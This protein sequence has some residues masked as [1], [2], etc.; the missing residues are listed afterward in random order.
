MSDESGTVANTV[1]KFVLQKIHWLDRIDMDDS[2]A[3]AA[4]AILRRGLGKEP[5]ALPEIW[6]IT[7]T[8]NSDDSQLPGAERDE[9][10]HGGP[11]RAERAVH[12][13]LTFYALHRQGQ[14]HSMHKGNA[15]KEDGTYFSDSSFG[16][17]MG[18]LRR[19]AA[20][21]PGVIRRFNAVI[22]AA[23]LTEF[24]RHAQGIVR[25]MRAAVV[26]IPMDY[27][28]FVR[29]LFWYQSPEKR[30]N[31]VMRWG[32]QFW[33]DPVEKKQSDDRTSTDTGASTEAR[34]RL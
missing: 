25:M 27:G 8:R 6:A 21:A 3:R 9:A 30:S 32:R 33:Y 13:A 26:P 23:D 18:Q 14:S 34:G 20:Q 4:L 12:T 11:T 5:D 15:K 31:V 29:D 10:R 28:V 7:M 22:T 17:A 24:A 2:G 16:A 19:N 1:A